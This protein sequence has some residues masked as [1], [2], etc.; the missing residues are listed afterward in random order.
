MNHPDTGA[1]I[2]PSPPLEGVEEAQAQAATPMVW[3]QKPKRL[4]QCSGGVEDV[5]GEKSSD[6]ADYLRSRNS[7]IGLAG[8]V[9]RGHRFDSYQCHTHLAGQELLPLAYPVLQI[10]PG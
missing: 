3:M 6:S 7:G 5:V 1:V 8:C 10:E 9:A 2:E 4:R